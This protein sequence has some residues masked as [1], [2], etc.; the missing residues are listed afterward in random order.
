V[1]IEQADR[2]QPDVIERD[3]YFWSHSARFYN[4]RN[5]RTG[6]RINRD[7]WK[8]IPNVPN[9][10]IHATINDVHTV[11]VLRSLNG[12][13]PHP[14]MSKRRREAWRQPPAQLQLFLTGD[15][16]LLDEDEPD[17][18]MSLNLIVDW[19]VD[20]FGEPVIHVGLPESDWEFNEEVRMHWREPLPGSEEEYQ[21][22]AFSPPKQD[23][24][25][26]DNL[27]RVHESE[28]GKSS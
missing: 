18:L 6:D 13:T 11:R 9:T 23:D 2:L 25:E 26:F 16:R 12:T 21:R 27:I 8:L 3:N 22:A 10:G 14:G 20:R 28:I 19:H 24:S 1:G 4:L 17:A 7:G 15:N 5:L